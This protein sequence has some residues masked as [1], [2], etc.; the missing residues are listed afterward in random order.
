M[1]SSTRNVSKKSSNPG[2]GEKTSGLEATGRPG[3]RT[4]SAPRPEDN[5]SAEVQAKLDEKLLILLDLESALGDTLA[6]FGELAVEAPVAP[7]RAA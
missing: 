5:I 3:P 2:S 7:E 1:R 4:T 6:E